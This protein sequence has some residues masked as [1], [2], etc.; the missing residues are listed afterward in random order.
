MLGC[1]VMTKPASSRCNLDCQYCFYIAKPPRPVMSEATLEC[2]IKQYI[3]AQTGPDV[4]FAWQGGE[5]TL[6]GQD[7]FRL[8][9][10]LQRRYGDGKRITNAFQTNG[11]LLTDNW[12]RFFQQHHWLVGISLDGPEDLHNAL[13]VNRQGRG[14]YHKVMAAIKR[15]RSRR[16][17]FN[18]LTVVNRCNCR[19]PER[20][21]RSLRSLGTP[22]LQFIPLVDKENPQAI[23]GPEWGHFLKRVFDIWVQ[24]DIGQV[25]VQLFDSTLGVWRGYPSQLCALSQ[26][27][28]HAFALEANGDVY[29]C[30][31]FVEPAHLLGNIHRKPLSALNRHK[32]AVAFGRQ[33]LTTLAE[34]CHRCSVRAFCHGDCPR[35][36]EEGKSVLCSGYQDFFRYSAPYMQAMRNLIQQQR[37]PS[38]LMRHLKRQ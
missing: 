14:T 37:S 15:L 19:H 6:C 1:Q 18:I 24:E 21:Y 34:E 31:H 16:V 3:S 7:F 32:D 23:S 4:H 8:V 25:F 12:C 36:R 26:T 20:V 13:R 29:Q 33:K 35:H 10:E 30:D 17:S 28:G 38:E 9:V 27:C 22:F 11:I 5:P 2:F